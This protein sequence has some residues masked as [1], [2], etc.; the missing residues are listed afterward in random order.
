M[1]FNNLSELFADGMI[2]HET[3]TDHDTNA[4]LAESLVP[5]QQS[6]DDPNDALIPMMIEFDSLYLYALE[7]CKKMDKN[8]V[9]SSVKRQNSV[10]TPRQVSSGSNF[11]VP[12]TPLTVIF[13]AEKILSQLEKSGKNLVL[14]C[15]P[16]LDNC[17]TNNSDRF[18]RLVLLNHL[19]N[20]GS[21]H[22]N[23]FSFILLE[24]PESNLII[25]DPES[26][27]EKLWKLFSSLSPFCLVISH[28]NPLSFLPKY[29]QVKAILARI[30]HDVA[31]QIPILDFHD[32]YHQLNGG[33]HGVLCE[34]R[35]SGTQNSMEYFVDSFSYLKADFIFSKQSQTD[36][37][38]KLLLA[39][40]LPVA[41]VGI[42]VNHLK[43][44]KRVGLKSRSFRIK[45]DWAQLQNMIEKVCGTVS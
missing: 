45:G 11:E 6:L 3:S 23:S 40:E 27:R 17:Y 34:F 37:Q 7:K 26:C 15:F 5:T 4:I 8:G 14:I 36:W 10:A 31:Q 13:T 29:Q 18:I 38:E 33:M 16:Q 20:L 42:W 28:N 30:S 39:S 1:P 35:H 19:L 12:L 22:K 2:S 9:V 43:T 32:I 41:L 44:L 21:D 25:S 24:S